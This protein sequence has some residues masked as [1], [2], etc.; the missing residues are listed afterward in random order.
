ML[1]ADG[2][3]RLF[4]RRGEPLLSPSTEPLCTVSARSPQ[5][6]C[7]CEEVGGPWSEVNMEKTWR[8]NQA[9]HETWQRRCCLG[10]TYDRR[11]SVIELNAAE[12][13][14]APNLPWVQGG[15][16]VKQSPMM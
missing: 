7:Q 8:K 6:A 16:A 9:C 4:I 11:P 15:H 10:M 5:H 3:T 1:F 14:S 2:A 13:T 12:R